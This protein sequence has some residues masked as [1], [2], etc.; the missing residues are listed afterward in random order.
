MVKIKELNALRD[1]SLAKWSLKKRVKII[2]QPTKKEWEKLAVEKKIVEDVLDAQVSDLPPLPSAEEILEIEKSDPVFAQE[3]REVQARQDILDSS[4]TAEYGEEVDMTH[5]FYSA[6]IMIN[7]GIMGL[8]KDIPGLKYF[9]LLLKKYK[10]FDYF[11]FLN[12][13]LIMK[14]DE[15]DMLFSL[16]HEL[17]HIRDFEGSFGTVLTHEEIDREAGLLLKE[18][19]QSKGN[20]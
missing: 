9:R 8:A 15:D 12:R 14:S 17:V 7:T 13:D 1:Y 4:I 20:K 3:I 2:H 19:L 6:G 5:N 16:A 11:I 10:F 18:F